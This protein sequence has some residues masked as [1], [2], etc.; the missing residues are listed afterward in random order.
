M[1]MSQRITIMPRSCLRMVFRHCFVLCGSC[2]KYTSG[3]LRCG[4]TEIF[5]HSCFWR[6]CFL[7]T[8]LL[9]IYSFITYRHPCF[10][11]C[12]PYWMISINILLPKEER[13]DS[14][15]I[16]R[17]IHQCW[18]SQ[19]HEPVLKCVAFRKKYSDERMKR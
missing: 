3:F 2:S 1:R 10:S 9:Q 6:L 5:L 15:M 8:M 12:L 11:S 16:S 17:I 13:P 4:K 19:K 7:F 18:L 14:R